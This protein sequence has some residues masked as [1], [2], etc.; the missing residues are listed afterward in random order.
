M[1]G[2]LRDPESGVETAYFVWNL[3]LIKNMGFR[4]LTVHFDIFIFLHGGLLRDP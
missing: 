3:D 1:G 4:R 2:L